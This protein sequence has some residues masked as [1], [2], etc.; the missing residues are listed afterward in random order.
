MRNQK[1]INSQYRLRMYS[2]TGL[3]AEVVGNLSKMWN[4]LSKEEMGLLALDKTVAKMFEEQIAKTGVLS[5]MEEKFKEYIKLLDWIYILEFN[6]RS[7]GFMAVGGNKILSLWVDERHRR[8]G[9]GSYL[10]SNHFEIFGGSLEL[11]CYRENRKALN[12]YIRN[13]FAVKAQDGIYTDLAS[14]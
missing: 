7:V 5:F 12:F 1:Y 4:A 3:D 6:N 14:I 11:Q 2:P 10:I 9:R 13:G 8:G